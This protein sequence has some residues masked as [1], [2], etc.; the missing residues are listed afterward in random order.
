MR[1]NYCAPTACQLW[2]ANFYAFCYVCI[3]SLNRQIVR[4]IVRDVKIKQKRSM[5]SVMYRQ[6]SP[7]DAHSCH[8]STAINHHVPDRLKSSFVIFDIRALWRSVLSVRVPGCQKLQ[9]TAYNPVWHGMLYSCTH[10]ATVGVK[11]SV[12]TSPAARSSAVISCCF[13]S[14]SFF[15]SSSAAVFTSV[16][17]SCHHI[18]S[19][20]TEQ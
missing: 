10:M 18:S 3:L 20:L 8:M 11:G 4:T 7:F 9:M 19:S 5:L 2:C 17:S 12:Y 6:I 15:L 13:D 16:I 14:W 1:G